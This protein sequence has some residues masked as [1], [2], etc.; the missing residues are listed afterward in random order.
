M[1]QWLFQ[2]I[3]RSMRLH[4]IRT[5]TIFLLKL[6]GVKWI[7][8]C[9]K[10][11]RSFGSACS[12]MILPQKIEAT[13]VAAMANYQDHLNVIFES[14][15]LCRFIPFQ[16]AINMFFSSLQRIIILITHRKKNGILLEQ[17]QNLNHF[18]GRQGFESIFFSFQ[19]RKKVFILMKKK[20]FISIKNNV[21][22][23]TAKTFNAQ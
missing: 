14:I 4:V 22:Y 7:I 12:S 10:R 16:L 13:A 3:F 15:H 9:F 5:E 18:I 1:H 20:L 21:P 17:F 2:L 19:W 23:Q 11:S 8:K 6:L